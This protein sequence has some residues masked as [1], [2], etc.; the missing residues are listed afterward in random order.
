MADFSKDENSAFPHG[1]FA[2]VAALMIQTGDKIILPIYHRPDMGIRIKSD[3]TPV[4]EADGKA[5]IALREGLASLYPGAAFIGEETEGAA[6]DWRE[7][8]LLGRENGLWKLDPDR[9]VFV[10]DPI[11]GTINFAQGPKAGRR[12]ATMIAKFTH[13]AFEAS[14]I[15]YPL[16]REFLFTSATAPSFLMTVNR[17]GAF[18][19]PRVVTIP[20]PTN[21]PLECRY[22]LYGYHKDPARH[23]QKGR[24]VFGPLVG[25]LGRLAQMTCIAEDLYDMVVTGSVDIASSPLYGTPWDVWTTAPV[26]E[27]AG[28]AVKAVDGKNYRSC[29]STGTV[30]A[31]AQEL[32]DKACAAASVLLAA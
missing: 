15:Y 8:P 9:T 27:R 18:D 17:N 20:T 10:M 19:A 21:R 25:P 2:P 30:M 22:F 31:R 14:W 32:A 28:A 5:E 24:Q 1:V 23:E 13:G 11:D 16:T 12:F 26:F 3:Y 6:G 4:T 29:A 7:S